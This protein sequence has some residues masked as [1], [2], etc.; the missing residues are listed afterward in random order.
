[1]L[2]NHQ[3]GDLYKIAIKVWSKRVLL[4]VPQSGVFNR[5]S[6][7]SPGLSFTKVSVMASDSFEAQLAE[8]ET[9]F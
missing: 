3:S 2:K 6:R 8:A 9:W 7:S 1:M 4:R 5:Y